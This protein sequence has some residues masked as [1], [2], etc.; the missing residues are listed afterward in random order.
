M[1]QSPGTT[2]VAHVI[3]LAVAPVFLLLGIGTM[4]MVLTNRLSRVIDR[5]RVLEGRQPQHP[6][7]ADAIHAQLDTLRRRAHL[8][9]RAITLCT[10]TALLLCVV[11]AVLFLSAFYGFDA[12]TPVAL[13]FIAAMLTLIGALVAFLREIFVA[14]ASLRIGAR[15][16]GAAST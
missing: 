6:E 7:E 12:T 8:V 13:L 9:N 16:P 5:G 14:T 2:D 11:I 4:L 10:V 3:Q 1:I 15:R